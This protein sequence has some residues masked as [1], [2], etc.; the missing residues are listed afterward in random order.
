MNISRK[1][2]V[3]LIILAHSGLWHRK[4]SEN[5]QIMVFAKLR[6][7]LKGITSQVYSQ[8]SRHQ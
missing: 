3:H 4:K 7:H 6:P 1:F 8:L 2:D 5:Y